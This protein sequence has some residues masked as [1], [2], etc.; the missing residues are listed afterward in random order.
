[1]REAR[2]LN[3]SPMVVRSL[4]SFF[5]GGGGSLAWQ[6]TAGADSQY[7]DLAQNPVNHYIPRSKAFTISFHLL[8]RS[9]GNVPHHVPA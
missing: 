2:I 3:L 6:D 7:G 8:L 1:M 5:W 9:G 4:G